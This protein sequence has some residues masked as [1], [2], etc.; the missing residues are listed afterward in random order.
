MNARMPAV[1]AQALAPMAPPQ[2]EVHRIVSD[3]ERREIMEIVDRHNDDY[4]TG[5]DKV[6][7]P[8]D[9]DDCDEVAA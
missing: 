7:P 2:S 1:L 9:R 8:W 4:R 6:G 5:L 3:A